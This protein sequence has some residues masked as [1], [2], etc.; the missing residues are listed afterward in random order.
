MN[1]KKFIIFLIIVST[2]LSLCLC[3]CADTTPKDDNTD[4]EPEDVSWENNNFNF[5]DDVITFVYVEG[6]QGEFTHISI[7]PDEDDGDPVVTALY[8][9][10]RK[11][12]EAYHVDI[13]AIQGAT[14]I[15]G[16]TS[17]IT[18]SLAA[19]SED[20]DVVAGYQ[21]YDLGLARNGYL[22]DLNTLSDYGADYL[23]LDRDYWGTNYIN[24]L[25]YNNKIYWITGDISLRYIGG[26]YCTFV[27]GDIYNK[28]LLDT[29][30][31]I[32]DV[33]RSGDWT[34]DTMIAM[35]DAAYDDT[36]GS[37]KV[38]EEDRV[39]YVTEICDDSEA[40][41][42]AAGVKFSK[43]D[44]DG[45][46]TIAFK[47]DRTVEFCNKYYELVN[48]TGFLEYADAS[49]TKS[50][51][52]FASENTLFVTNKLFQAQVYLTEMDNYYVIPLPKLNK[53]QADYISYL[54]DGCTIFGINV[55]TDVLPA[56]AATLDAMA[57]ES[58]EKV[59]PIYYDSALK[60]KYT[61][62]N[63]SAEMIDL[64]HRTL[65]TDFAAAWSNSISDIAHFFRTYAHS[66]NKITSI[67]SKQTSKWKESL[68]TLLEQLDEASEL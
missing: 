51:G 36:N 15:S 24:A 31:S 62:D 47:T 4:Q 19:G 16:L 39:G 52:N 6:E 1:I 67:I 33:V 29:Y 61:R 55:S 48:S 58:H 12:E 2:L 17:A 13:E 21:Y 64:I 60:Y 54:H 56:A 3:A 27:N 35:S 59:S 65:I 7:E 37:E 66:L 68:N 18:S 42:I 5:N 23:H 30:G 32:Y 14:S 38:D 57:E 43:T 8:E 53:E 49:S 34:I 44:V 11:I 22:Y 46:V 28:V 9:R 26:M 50:M 45:K 63:D 25:S 40:M 20:Y 10:N 41:A